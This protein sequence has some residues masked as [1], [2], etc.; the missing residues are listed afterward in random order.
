MKELNTAS[1]D[2]VSNLLTKNMWDLD[3]GYD[4]TKS[5]AAFYLNGHVT[6]TD[7]FCSALHFPEESTDSDE[8]DFVCVPALTLKKLFHKTDETLSIEVEQKEHSEEDGVAKISS[9]RSLYSIPSKTDIP[10]SELMEVEPFTETDCLIQVEKTEFLRALDH[11]SKALCKDDTRY[12]LNALCFALRGNPDNCSLAMVATDASRLHMVE[13]QDHCTVVDMAPDEECIDKNLL[14][15]IPTTNLLSKVL[16]DKQF[17]YIDTVL[18][19]FNLEKGLANI[20]LS[21]SGDSLIVNSRLVNGTFPQYER[22]VGDKRSKNVNFN[23]EKGKDHWDEVKKAAKIYVHENKC[24]RFKVESGKFIAM[25]ENYN[26]GEFKSTLDFATPDHGIE[27]ETMGINFDFLLEA[28]AGFNS[29]NISMEDKTNSI[30]V[31]SPDYPEY[32]AVI[33]PMRV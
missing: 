10:Y 28:I 11:I 3:H 26:L 19:N 25:F 30:T 6:L 13:I 18:I 4:F 20:T 31:T 24:F 7:F 27:L 22:I 32:Q 2:K 14:L 17:S 16:K 23:F 9:T 21:G 1:I 12:A 15:P 5:S 29:V 8:K 33:M